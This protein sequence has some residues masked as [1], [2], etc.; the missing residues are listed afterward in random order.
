MQVVQT[1]G[2]GLSVLGGGNWGTDGSA[3]EEFDR[4]DAFEAGASP[5]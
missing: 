2:R 4:P 5:A 1:C 3:E